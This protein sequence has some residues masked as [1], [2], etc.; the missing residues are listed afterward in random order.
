MIPALHNAVKALKNQ[1][2]VAHFRLV[3]QG[4]HGAAD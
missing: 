2:F 1:A 4:F 3:R